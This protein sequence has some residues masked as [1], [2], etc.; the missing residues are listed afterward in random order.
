MRLFD[1]KINSSLSFKTATVAILL[2]VASHTAIVNAQQRF[3]FEIHTNPMFC[4]FSS[5]SSDINGKSAK[6]GFNFG[7][8]FNKYFSENYA[9][10]TGV[11]LITSGGSFSY[12]DTIMLNLNKPVTAFPESRLV[13]NVKYVAIPVGIKLR[14]NQIGYVS[15]FTNIGLDPKFVLG[16]NVEIPAQN[17]SKKNADNELNKL[18]MGYHVIGGIEYSLGGNTAIVVGVNFDSNFTK[19]LKQ[20]TDKVLHK[21]LGLHLGLNF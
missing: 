12:S 16:G 15:L 2:I 18:S 4:W 5:Y 8:T 9:F 11:S 14:S 17:I 6:G 13:Y 19:I 1:M 21:M 7:L 3:E 20:P 10:S